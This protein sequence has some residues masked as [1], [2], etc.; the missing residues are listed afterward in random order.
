MVLVPAA[1]NWQNMK[2][3]NVLTTVTAVVLSWFYLNSV[4][5]AQLIPPRAKINQSEPLSTLASNHS[6]AATNRITAGASGAGLTAVTARPTRGE[7]AK[8]VKSLGAGMVCPRWNQ[9]LPKAMVAGGCCGA[10][11][12]PEVARPACCGKP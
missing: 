4:A 2:T 11:K 8:V 10:A 7:D 6:H 9:P 12:N 3:S 1:G 5:P